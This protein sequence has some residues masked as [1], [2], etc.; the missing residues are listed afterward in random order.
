MRVRWHRDPAASGPRLRAFLP[1]EYDSYA[2]GAHE[3]L[4]YANGDWEVR[5]G[6]NGLTLASGSEKGKGAGG[7]AIPVHDC[8]R[9]KRRALLVYE[10]LIAAIAL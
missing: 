1:N 6:P 3:L 4:V 9:A 7:V 8:E 10:A 2:K 5:G